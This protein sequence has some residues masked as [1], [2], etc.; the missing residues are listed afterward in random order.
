MGARV[1]ISV[2]TAYDVARFRAHFPALT[3]GAAHFDGPG[4]SQTPDVVGLAMSRTC[5]PVRCPTAAGLTVAERNADRAVSEG[6]GGAGRPP[7]CRSA[8]GRLRAQL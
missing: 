7:E 4:G 2:H 6:P 5:W 8:R 1:L 3:D